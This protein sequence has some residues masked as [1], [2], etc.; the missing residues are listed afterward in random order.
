MNTSEQS[1]TPPTTDPLGLGKASAGSDKPGHLQTV[2]QLDAWANEVKA[3]Q[4]KADA[5]IVG[6]K[7]LLAGRVRTITTV[8]LHPDG[9]VMVTYDLHGNDIQCYGM[10]GMVVV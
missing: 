6:R 8:E 10:K 4:A 3:L 2:M 9:G 5:L 1:Q 7:V